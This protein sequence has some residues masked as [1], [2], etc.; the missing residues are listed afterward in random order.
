MYLLD[1]VVLS[2][3]RRRERDPGLVSWIAKQRPTD[4]FLSVVTI[5]EIERG[6][7]LQQTKNAHFA[8]TL[9]AW[10]D[11]TMHLYADR[12]LQIDTAVARR[13]GRLSAE[14]GNDGADLLIAAT[15]QEHGLTVIT[16]NLRH[17]VPT[18][19]AALNPWGMPPE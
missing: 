10:L 3:L 15:A 4:L 18:G 9:S 5:G 11:K 8:T 12:I 7:V 13:W 14:I 2:E 17:F 1:T 16:R 6:I 19:I